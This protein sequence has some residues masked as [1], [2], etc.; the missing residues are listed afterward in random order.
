MTKTKKILAVVTGVTMLPFLAVANG[1]STYVEHETYSCGET[2]FIATTDRTWGNENWVQYLVVDDGTVHVE[3]IEEGG[4][5]GAEVT[6]GP[7]QV[8]EKTIYYR[9]FGGPERDDDLPL[10]NGHPS[11][12]DPDLGDYIGENGDEWTL[13]GSDDPNPFVTWNSIEVEGCPAE[14]DV[15]NEGELAVTD[16]T[17]EDGTAI[18]NNQYEDGWSFI[19]DI[20]LPTSETDVAMQFGEWNGPTPF[21]SADNMRISSAQASDTSPVEVTAESTYT[22]PTLEIVED[23]DEET[24]GIQIQILVEVKI[25][26]GTDS[27][28]YSTS[29][30]VQSS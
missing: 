11:F 3:Q 4:E 18:A 22:S 19:F 10:W 5:G 28:T 14:G 1:G 9:V 12:D 2:T 15:E 21:T 27:G 8:A 20:T 17:V 29:Y 23:L 24:A 26:I 30:G 7:Y 13:Y 16:I 6:V 25:P